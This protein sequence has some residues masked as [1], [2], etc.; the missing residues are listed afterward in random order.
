VEVLNFGI[1]GYNTLHE[2]AQLK[3]L[4]FAFRPDV[5]VVGYLYNDIELSTS[6]RKRLGLI[7][8]PDDPA[9]AGV[10]RSLARE[11]KSSINA[12]VVYMK[13]HSYFFAWLSPRLG[14]LVRPFGIKG[15]GQIGEVADMYVDSAPNWKTVR[16]ALLEMKRLCDERNIRLVVT[17]I[18]AMT[19]FT[20]SHYPLKAYHT[21][22]TRF[23]RTHSI[24]CFDLL[25]SFWGLDG[26]QLWISPTD[27]HPNAE[28]HRIMAAALSKHLATVL[29]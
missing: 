5:V 23:C 13:L 11:V 1:P 25:P 18:P 17:I 20:D 9:Q 26:T 19:K 2:L 21:A 15:F 29:P 8:P 22:V 12:A 14:V 24:D 27:G 10:Q 16:D 6:Q 28:G 7:K 3:Q 4:G